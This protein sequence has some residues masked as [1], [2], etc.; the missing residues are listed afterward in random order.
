MT[1]IPADDSTRVRVSVLCSARIGVV[2]CETLFP[3]LVVMRRSNRVRMKAIIR[4][5]AI[6]SPVPTNQMSPQL[7]TVSH[8]SIVHSPPRVIRDVSA[9]FMDEPGVNA[10]R[11]K[12]L[13]NVILEGAQP[14]RAAF[15][16]RGHLRSDHV[17][18]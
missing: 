16:H 5:S 12:Y 13:C 6:C 15:R 1:T 10:S 3:T 9:V 18:P 8:H 14:G 2:S 17:A 4:T 7:L 11:P